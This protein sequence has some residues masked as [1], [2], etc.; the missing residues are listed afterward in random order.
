MLPAAPTAAQTATS[1]L[2]QPAVSASVATT[3]WTCLAGAAIE[4]A[5]VSFDTAGVADTW[6]MVH[7]V[8]G[9][10]IA[11]ERISQRQAEQLRHLSCSARAEEGAPI[12]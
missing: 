11:A 6:V 1:K 2:V 8:K 3:Q 7:R 4:I 5:P 9:E 10:V 12:G